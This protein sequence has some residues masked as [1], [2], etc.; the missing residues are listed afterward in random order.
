[1]AMEVY[2][3]FALAVCRQL[4]AQFNITLI[5]LG[6][7]V[8]EAGTIAAVALYG[9]LWSGLRRNACCVGNGS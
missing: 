9:K 8:L 5:G 4:W 7:T 1:M 6:L 3:R 2:T